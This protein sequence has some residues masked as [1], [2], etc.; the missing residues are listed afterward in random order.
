M[1]RAE[2]SRDTIYVGGEWITPGGLV[3][4]VENP[5]TEQV[6][7]TIRTATAH[8]AANAVLA[9]RL[10]NQA[11]SQTTPAYRRGLLLDLSVALRSREEII[12]ETLVA[13]V[14]APADIALSSHLGQA[15]AVLDQYADLLS[16]FSFSEVVGHTRVLREPAG[17]VAAITPWNYPLYQL[18]AK[19]APALAAGCPVVA[20]PAELTPLSAFLLA[21]A[22]E[23]IGLPAGVFNL[24]PGSGSEVG[25]VLSSH[26]DVDVVSFTGSVGVGRIV[27]A[28]ASDTVKRVCL[29]LGGKSASIVL[30][31]AD[32]ERAVTATVEN[33]MFNSGQTCAAWTRLLVPQD[34]LDEAL[35]TAASVAD[36]L[37]VGDPLADGTYLGPVISAKQRDSVLAFIDGAVADGGSVV[38]GGTTR[39]DDLD[40]GHY[41]RPTVIAGLPATSRVAQEEV[42]GPVLVVLPYD[43][44]D[45]AVAI[46]NDSA[47]GLG[48][49]VW[50]DDVDEAFAVAQRLRTGRVDINGAEWN[51]AAP[52]GGYKQS[53]NGREMGQWGL[54][55]FL[56]VKAVQMPA[57]KG[58]A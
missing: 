51:P 8:D 9:A 1:T 6:V 24:V 27:A 25:G 26:P 5:A 36:S 34:R 42:F 3:C 14:G 23:E 46:A 45:D 31:S 15:L 54:D 39:P 13:E 55:E 41:L 38:A 18:M 16:T 17:V 30:P 40:T 49:A 50:A 21:D 56:E 19:V 4:D 12:V 20:K 43:D 29:E 44:V 35:V 10:A 52:F 33:V 11:W 57:A 53:G 58:S 28:T 7:G 47:Y 2:W 22:L 32:L 37:V 48:G